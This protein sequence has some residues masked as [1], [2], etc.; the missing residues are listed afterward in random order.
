V[1]F[2][3]FSDIHSN[4]EAL[5]AV[6][7]RVRKRKIDAYLFLG[8]I[9]GYGANPNEVI[10]VLGALSNLVSIRGN[11]DK[12]VMGIESLEFFNPV[13]AQAIQWTKQRLNNFSKKF[14]SSLK[15]GP[16]R[17]KEGIC[18]CHGSPQDEDYYIFTPE[19]AY[20]SLDFSGER[21][22]FFGHT[23]VPVVYEF[24][25]PE[26]YTVYYPLEEGRTT[27]KLNPEYK[28]M[29]NPGSVGQPR[30]RNPRASYLIFD[31]SKQVVQF[32]RIPYRIVNARSKILKQGLPPV[33]GD[34]LLEGY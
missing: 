34:R 19:E 10:E 6:L 20:A 2:L 30:D 29:I 3:V 22:C 13:A 15:K 28:Y 12:V 31:E 26:A 5:G 4:L 17:I 16:L 24:R 32:Y 8:D 18:I 7:S 11:H 27:I 33:L 21:I 23:H 14:L 9:I 25:T 1:K